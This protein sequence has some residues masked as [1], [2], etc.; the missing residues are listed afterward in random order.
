MFLLRQSIVKRLP[1]LNVLS[2]L[3]P[4]FLGRQISASGVWHSPEMLER[5]E[6]SA[7]AWH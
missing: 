2:L 6:C 4:F 7:R 1:L 3:A 5:L